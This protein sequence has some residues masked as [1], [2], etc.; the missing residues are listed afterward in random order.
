MNPLVSLVLLVTGLR[1]GRTAAAS[2]SSVPAAASGALAAGLVGLAAL[3]GL[4]AV[5][6]ACCVLGLAAVLFL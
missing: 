2:G 3:A 1:A 6:V 4:T 5:V